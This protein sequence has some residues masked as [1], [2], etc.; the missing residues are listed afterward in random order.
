[1]RIYIPV[2]VK[3]RE[4][5]AK[6][7]L[8]Q[9]LMRSGFEVFLGRKSEIQKLCEYAR[10]GIFLAP[11]AFRNFEN[12]FQ[13]LK[14]RGFLIA[15][16]EEEGLVTYKS[17]MYLDM[18]LD[19]SVLSMV[20]LFIAWGEEGKQIVCQFFQN[21][22]FRCEAI[23]NPRVDLTKERNIQLYENEANVLQAQY[24]NFILFVSSFSA[25]NHF[26][27][28]MDYIE[29]LK[30]K[31]T[32][33]SETSVTNFL[34]YFKVKQKTFS[35]FLEAIDVLA[36]QMPEKNFVVRPHP[37]E[38]SEPYEFLE[39]TNHNVYVD[40]Q[41]SIHPWIL[42][43]QGIVHHYCTTAI[44]AALLKKPIFAFRPFPDQKSEKEFPFNISQVS[45]TIPQ[46][47]S[48]IANLETESTNFKLSNTQMRELAYHVSGVNMDDVS[49]E[50]AICLKQL[51]SAK[52]L[53][54]L[55]IDVRSIL[56]FL[57]DLNPSHKKSQ[58]VDHKFNA[59]ETKE[60]YQILESTGVEISCYKVTSFKKH[61][62]RMRKK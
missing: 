31:K 3:T 21:D 16:N 22:N 58:Y 7:L 29:E 51:A 14:K 38:S 6:V 57:K 49:S 35:S 55:A 23:G 59:I 46:L 30:K 12:Y 8:S 2:E 11:G 44:E 13:R 61:V 60:V 53:P 1:M 62:L 27:P 32:L 43:S 37:S 41:H 50:I 4:L 28:T 52:K 20:D 54:I 48:S 5:A 18:R 10:P 34:R 39:Q 33:R 45:E 17:E 42:A 15:V 40:G 47:A 36:K 24:G 56:N 26:D 25:V 9:R 19:K